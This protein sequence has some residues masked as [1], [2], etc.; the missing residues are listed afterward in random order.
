MSLTETTSSR[1]TDKGRHL[2][3]HGYLLLENML[4]KELFVEPVLDELAGVVSTVASQWKR[5]GIIARTWERE[6]LEDQL[7]ALTSASHGEKR[8][9]TAELLHRHKPAEGRHSHVDTDVPGR[10]LFPAT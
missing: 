3:E 2:R 6:R 7:L 8:A 9:P 5:Q 4:D 1:P 10:S